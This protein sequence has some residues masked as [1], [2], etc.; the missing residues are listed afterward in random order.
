[1]DAE[2]FKHHLNG[3]HCIFFL[4]ELKKTSDFELALL[5]ELMRASE[6]IKNFRQLLSYLSP[7]ASEGDDIDESVTFDLELEALRTMVLNMLAA[8]LR[9]AL[10]VFQ[11][12]SK[13]ECFASIRT[14][15]TSEGLMEVE[16][17]EGLN[18]DF[19]GQK[20]LVFEILRP[21]R[22]LV[23]HYHTDK[24]DNRAL[25]WVKK[26]KELE[27]YRKPPYQQ[28]DPQNYDFSS[29][30]DFD[31][32]IYSEHLFHG[33]EG[34]GSGFKWQKLVWETQLHF[35]EATKAIVLG[36]LKHEGIPPRKRDW[37]SQYLH[38]YRP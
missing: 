27:A 15:I 4:S 31:R 33:K 17:L 10:Q 16:I 26:V 1:M 21:L 7:E 34:I 2:E 24:K 19:D 13:T 18:K 11:A 5:I 23:F 3:E 38:G 28:L 35:L 6:H 12:F 9:E 32:D 37:A 36:V 29:G 25:E 22:N 14:H 8:Q 30:M 20:G